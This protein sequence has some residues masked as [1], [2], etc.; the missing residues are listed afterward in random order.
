ME[1]KTET[2]KREIKREKER[3]EKEKELKKGRQTEKYRKKEKERKKGPCWNI[4][5]RSVIQIDPKHVQNIDVRI[6]SDSFLKADV[7]VADRFG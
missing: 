6:V 4:S 7:F 3:S 5:E 1:R 2:K